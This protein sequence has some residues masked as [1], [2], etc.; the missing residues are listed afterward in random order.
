[1]PIFDRAPSQM[2]SQML[3]QMPSQMLSQIVDRV[4]LDKSS[5]Y[6]RFLPVNKQY[7]LLLAIK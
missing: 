7:Y 1:M 5:N 6:T 2:P 4:L 3:R